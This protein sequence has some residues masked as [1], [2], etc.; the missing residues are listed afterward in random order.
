[1][2][3]LNIYMISCCS[4]CICNL[5]ACLVKIS[6]Y[7]MCLSIVTVFAYIKGIFLCAIK[8][9]TPKI[10]ERSSNRRET[11]NVDMFVWMQQDEGKQVI[12]VTGS[13]SYLLQACKRCTE[14][15]A[16]PTPNF[17]F[18]TSSTRC[19]TRLVWPWPGCSIIHF[20]A[21]DRLRIYIKI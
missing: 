9:N 17:Y 14:V 4:I 16:L 21:S 1:M 6:K 10:L 20:I 5:A 11:K 19:I 18:I 15:Q 3:I 13:D 7:C 8:A 2:C 12:I